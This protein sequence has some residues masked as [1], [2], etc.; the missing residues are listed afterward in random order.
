M[1]EIIILVLLTKKLKA[2]AVAKGRSGGWAALGPLCWIGGEILGA[3]LGMAFG[4]SELSLYG[5]ALAGA[6]IGAAIAWVVVN[7]L[8]SNDDALASNVGLDDHIPGG[9]YDPSNPYNAPGVM[10][11][12]NPYQAA[13][14]RKPDNF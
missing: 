3:V 9:H 13:P 5:G 10:P 6:A 11:S 14:P 4:M 2:I 1:L 8:S 7:G 12:G